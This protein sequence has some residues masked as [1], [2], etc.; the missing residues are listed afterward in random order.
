MQDFRAPQPFNVEIGPEP[1]VTPHEAMPV[2]GPSLPVVDQEI[3][4]DVDL[5]PARGRG[6]RNGV[7]R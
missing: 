6:V 5:Y 2:G 7:V 1:Q 3:T 4:Q